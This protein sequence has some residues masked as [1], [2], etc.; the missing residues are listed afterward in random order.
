MAS[1]SL[2]QILS[3][4]QGA[5]YAM[6]TS[7]E[8]GVFYTAGGDRIVARWDL[9]GSSPQEGVMVARAAEVVYSLCLLSEQGLLLVGQA[10][11]G[12]HAIDLDSRKEVRLLQNHS[13]PVFSLVSI[14]EHGLL[15]SVSGD[16]TIAWLTRDLEV[17]SRVRLTDKKMR[18]LVVHPSGDF[19]L[20]GCG[21]GSIVQ[22]SLPEG[23]I[24][25]RFQAHQIDFSV[26]AIAFSPDGAFFMTG[27]RDAMLN[28]YETRTLKLLET[29]PA[30]NYAIYDIAF[31]PSGG[32]FATASRDKTI[33]FWNYE[34]MEVLA[35]F[36]GS[37]G[38]SHV[39]SVNR[40]SWL[41][42]RTLLSA[43]DDRSIR[44]WS[45]DSDQSA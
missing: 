13:A 39:N 22:L 25:N 15:A 18:C 20:A 24:E 5:V 16:G 31:H 38:K 44:V 10:E 6:V 11:G 33:K 12:V 42:D 21:D 43:G 35:R 34:R 41:D 40:L 27:S 28:L 23:K 32:N 26:N 19:A 4:H 45:L 17:R 8:P 29:I 7:G 9:Q 14:P 36:E 1:L 2:Q 30:H 3:G 37:D